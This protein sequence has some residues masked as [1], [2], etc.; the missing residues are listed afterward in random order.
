MGKTVKCNSPNKEKWLL[1]SSFSLI[2][3]KRKELGGLDVGHGLPQSTERSTEGALHFFREVPV[4]LEFVWQSCCDPK[5][6][7]SPGW[8][9]SVVERRPAN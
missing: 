4:S 2:R 3:E 7:G 1:L 9:G 6:L 5:Q 8:C